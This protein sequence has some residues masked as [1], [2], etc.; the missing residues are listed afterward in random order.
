MALWRIE[1]VD[2]SQTSRMSCLYV[3]E[4]A[5]RKPLLVKK[6]EKA[7]KVRALGVNRLHKVGKL[8]VCR[9]SVLLLVLDDSEARKLRMYNYK[10]SL[11]QFQ[12]IQR[13]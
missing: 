5:V 9:L 4:Y 3:P 8:A 10:L 2:E 6:C 1:N 12:M 7:L 13:L 11:S